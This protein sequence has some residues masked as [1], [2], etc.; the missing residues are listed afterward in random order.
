MGMPCH[1][2]GR[3]QTATRPNPVHAMSNQR[4]PIRGVTRTSNIQRVVCGKR[5]ALSKANKGEGNNK[6]R[7]GMYVTTTKVK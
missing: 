5:S 1:K 7:G 4:E 2:V 6:N 3:Q